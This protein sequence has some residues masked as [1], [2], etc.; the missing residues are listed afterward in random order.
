MSMHIPSWQQQLSAE[1]AWEAG[2]GSAMLAA[3][4]HNFV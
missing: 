2:L 3:V 1:G 4:L